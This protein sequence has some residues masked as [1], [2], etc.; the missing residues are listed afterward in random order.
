MIA[1]G[2]LALA[3]MPLAVGLFLSGDPLRWVL[4][5][6]T[7]VFM[8]GMVDITLQTY[9]AVLKAMSATHE[10]KRLTARF[11]RLARF[12][13]MTGLENRGAFQERLQSEVR[14]VVA[15]EGEQLAVL[16]IDLDK[17][18]EIND[19]LGH[20][21][22]DK[23]LC[24][25]SPASSPRSSTGRGSVA[26]FGGDEFVLLARGSKPGFA[27][28]LAREVM[29]GLAVP[30]NIE[31]VSIQVTGSIGVAVA[32]RDGARRR[33]PAPACRHGALPRQGRTAGTITAM[34]EPP[35]EEEFLEMRRLEAALRT[36]SRRASSKSITSRSSI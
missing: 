14:E 19:S 4:G 25:M 9:S 30:M 33:H 7:L 32:P 17:F 12:D 34:F 31:G 16:W 35:M 15:G 11:E 13:T 6:V 1:I 18:K 20:P 21:T 10:Q 29:R 26:R 3:S 23:V 24:Q 8:I 27:E 36:R 22:G 2:Q 28:D 5:A